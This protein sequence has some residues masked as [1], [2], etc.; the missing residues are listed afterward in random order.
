MR[1][2]VLICFLYFL[3][4]GSY[5]KAQDDV[6][7]IVITGKVS[8]P[9][10]WQVKN[11][12]NTLWVFGLLSPLPKNL[13][14]D[15]SQVERVIENADAVLDGVSFESTDGIGVIS[16]IGL[17]RQY[18]RFRK[19]MPGDT[20]EDVLPENIYAQLLEIKEL[21]G[22]RGRGVLKIRPLMAAQEINDSALKKVGLEESDDISRRINRLIKRSDAITIESEYTTDTPYKDLL[23]EIDA[24]PI[25]EEIACLKSTLESISTDINDMKER[26]I[27]WSYGYVGELYAM[28]FPNPQ[29]TCLS[30][31]TGGDAI[32]EIFNGAQ[33]LWLENAEYALK[34]YSSTFAVLPMYMILD[35][36]GLIESLA[37]RGY[38]IN[39][40]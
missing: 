34:N 27:S 13:D 18:R 9:P 6:H 4:I 15:S 10:L 25:E 3:C 8:G 16:G 5:S 29:E 28:Q 19:N 2:P 35:Q 33:A 31:L 12:E 14:W 22:P 32:S 39:E 30:A 37:A 1:L 36:N 17:Y 21:Y 11:G 23:A 40:P 38:E 7:E 20:L 26:A 24:M